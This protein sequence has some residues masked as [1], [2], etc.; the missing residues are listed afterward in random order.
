MYCP[1]AV[2]ERRHY[3]VYHVDHARCTH[4]VHVRFLMFGG[5]Y[6][7]ATLCQLCFRALRA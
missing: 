3:V 5:L 2:L 6:A 4:G 1:V 7:R